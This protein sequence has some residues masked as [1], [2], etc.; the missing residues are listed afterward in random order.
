MSGREGFFVTEGKFV[1][2]LTIS[3]R[4][5]LVDLVIEHYLE[6]GTS[7]EFVDILREKT[8]T[9]LDIL[10]LLENAKFIV[11]PAAPQ[12]TKQKTCASGNSGD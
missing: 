3:E 6:P 2:E 1:L 4:M 11:P 8:T 5:A 12:T 10:K 7:G 9:P